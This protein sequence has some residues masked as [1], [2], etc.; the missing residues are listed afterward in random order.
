MCKQRCKCSMRNTLNGEAFCFRGIPN[1]PIPTGWDN[2]H[3]GI[4]ARKYLKGEDGLRVG[5]TKKAFSFKHTRVLPYRHH[6][7]HLSQPA[8]EVCCCCM[9]IPHQWYS[10]ISFCRN[11]NHKCN[12]LLFWFQCSLWHRFHHTLCLVYQGL[13]LNY[14]I[15]SAFRT[16]VKIYLLKCE[17]FPCNNFPLYS[18]CTTV[19]PLLPTLELTPH[20]RHVH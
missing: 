6:Y 19:P 5:I 16:V 3:S 10:F 20:W 14:I 13:N 12:T 15:I 11:G 7:K 1:D 9:A 4:F 18:T 2:I 8:K 17:I